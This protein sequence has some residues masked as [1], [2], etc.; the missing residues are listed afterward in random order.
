MHQ[1]WS[2]SWCDDPLLQ[3]YCGLP[4]VL[5]IAER[6]WRLLR[7]VAF[8]V[9]VNTAEAGL[10]TLQSHESVPMTCS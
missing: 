4:L 3:L 7:N 10:M 8:K 9:L 1:V 5:Y 2:D 6:I